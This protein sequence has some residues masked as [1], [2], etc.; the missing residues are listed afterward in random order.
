MPQIPLYPAAIFQ[1]EN[2]GEGMSFVLY[3][4]LSDSYQ[5]EL[6]PHFQ[7]SILVSFIFNIHHG[8]SYRLPTHTHVL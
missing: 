5:K 1:S 6:P 2:D 3:F 4:K 8:Y 7:D